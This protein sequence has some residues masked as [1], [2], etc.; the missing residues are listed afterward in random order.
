M[1]E[2]W[3]QKHSNTFNEYLTYISKDLNQQKKTMFE[4]EESCKKIKESFG[5]KISFFWNCY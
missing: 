5:N 1:L 3:Q 4:N 2:K